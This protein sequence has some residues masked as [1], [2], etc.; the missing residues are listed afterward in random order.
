MPPMAATVGCLSL[1]G[2]Y[3]WQT[4]NPDSWEGWYW[5]AKHVWGCEPVGKAAYQ[6]NIIPDIAEN[7]QSYLLHIGCDPETTPWGWGG[8]TVSQLCYWFTELG[9]KQIYICPD[10][11][12]GAAVHADKW[13]PILPNTDAAMYLAIAYTWITEG[14]Y[15]KEYVKTHVVG[16]DKFKDY[17]LGKEDGIPK[18]PKWASEKRGIPSRTNQSSGQKLGS[19]LQPPLFM[20]MAAIWPGLLMLTKMPDWKSVLLGMQGLGKPGRHLLT[21]IEWGLFGNMD[22]SEMDLWQDYSCPQAFTISQSGT[23]Q[24]WICRSRN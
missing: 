22:P 14:T 8:Q 18:T 12:Y 11:N 7:T 1:L 2:G 13:I 15:D 16:F 19:R 5:G 9:I 24:P 17:V 3:T 6:S 20:P 4:R 21:T 10:L 23:D